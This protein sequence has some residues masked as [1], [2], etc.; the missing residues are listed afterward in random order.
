MQDLQSQWAGGRDIWP[1]VPNGDH[2][3]SL[4]TRVKRVGDNDE[5]N[6]FPWPQVLKNKILYGFGAYNPRG[7]VETD[8]YNNKHHEMLKADIIEGLI[9]AFP[10]VGVTLWWEAASLWE[11]GTSERGFIVAFEC[12]TLLNQDAGE[13]WSISLAEKYQQGA[14]YEFKYESDP[15]DPSKGKMHRR[16]IA[17]LD[18]GTDADVEIIL[19][20]LLHDKASNENLPEK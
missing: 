14:I 18:S 19:A 4:T 10:Q 8:D 6:I 3:I 7:I 2:T 17:V 12:D 20:S 13:N 15:T 9:R 11:D 5:T 1:A 16:T